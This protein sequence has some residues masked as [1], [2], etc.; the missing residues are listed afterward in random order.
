MQ[1]AAPSSPNVEARVYDL[2][3]T[4]RVVSFA[5]ANWWQSAFSV[6]REKAPE[7]GRRYDIRGV[8]R[9]WNNDAV[10]LANPCG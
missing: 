6:E 1:L 2:R 5:L 10:E 9:R 7:P 8:L 3:S 4:G